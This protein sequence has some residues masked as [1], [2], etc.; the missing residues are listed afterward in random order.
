[1]SL[2]RSGKFANAADPGPLNKTGA[3]FHDRHRGRSPFGFFNFNSKTGPEVGPGV[4]SWE[5]RAAL[6]HIE[7]KA[8]QTRPELARFLSPR[9]AAP[10]VKD[11]YDNWWP[12]PAGPVPD[13]E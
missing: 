9:P 6:D 10:W 5:L 2:G 1:V 11:D 8:I 12:N 4:L 13:P 7:A 3:A